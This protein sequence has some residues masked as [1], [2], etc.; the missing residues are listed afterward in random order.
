MRNRP[1]DPAARRA[2]LE[3][4]ATEQGGNNRSPTSL[5]R[6]WLKSRLTLARARI[7]I[8]SARFEKRVWGRGLDTEDPVRQP[9]HD[10][11]DRLVYAPS[12][13]HALPRALRYLGVSDHDTFVDFG[14][15]KGRVVHQAAKQPFRR[16]IGVE[17]SPVLAE[18][19]RTNLAARRH[20]HRCRNVEIVV[21]D[22]REFQVPDDLTIGYFLHPFTGQTFD[23]V[24]RGIVDSID[25]HPR[26]LRLIYLGPHGAEVLATGRFRL[27]KEQQSTVLDAH[28]YR[29]EIFESY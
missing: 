2:S 12:A 18:I 6:A 3:R 22:A 5:A 24:L 21:A 9:E 16:V 27:L 26:R 4:W 7:R 29:A 1:D 13:W 14:C 17:I 8:A 20:E 10:H 23:A 19:A 28:A 11:P 25:R 15:G